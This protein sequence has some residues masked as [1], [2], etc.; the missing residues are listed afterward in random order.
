[1]KEV[2][3]TEEEINKYKFMIIGKT[4]IVQKVKEG[5]EVNLAKD[6]ECWVFT[7]GSEKAGKVGYGWMIHGGIEG[8]GRARGE[9]NKLS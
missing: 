2:E 7:D 4:P 3:R 9:R 6:Q 1:M 5:K 8:Y